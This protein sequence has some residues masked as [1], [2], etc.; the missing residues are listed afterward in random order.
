M[1]YCANELDFSVST[2]DIFFL[3]VLVRTGSL[4]KTNVTA[5][6]VSL[7]LNCAQGTL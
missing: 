4:S 7:V 2:K 3:E 6:L 1:K 5:M